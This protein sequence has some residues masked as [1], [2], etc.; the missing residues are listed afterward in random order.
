[1]VVSV[2]GVV[3]MPNSALAEAITVAIL[4]CP[5]C[6]HC[7]AIKTTATVHEVVAALPSIRRVLSLRVDA[8][9]ACRACGSRRGI[10]YSLARPS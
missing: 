10:T 6:V 3:L 5:L 7:I 4:D 9:T 8:L 2:L 1:L